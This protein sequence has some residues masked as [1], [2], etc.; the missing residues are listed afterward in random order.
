MAI[1]TLPTEV[2]RQ[3][4]KLSFVSRR[5]ARAGTGGEHVSRRPAPSTDFVDYRPYHP[6][7]D[8]RRVDWNIYGRLG[9]LQVKVTEGRERLSV[10]IVLDCSSSMDFGEP[11]KLTF[12]CQLV[13]ALAHIGVCRAD[14]VR[15]TCLG[16][17]HSGS[18]SPRR[19][20]TVSD[21][22]RQ[23]SGVAPVGLVDLNAGLATCVPAGAAAPSGS[24]AVI[25]SDLLTPE[26]VMLGLDALCAR[27]ADVALVHVVAPDELE[28]RLSGEVTLVDAESG[29][30]LELGVST[31]TLSAYRRR[32]EAWV[33]AREAD[34]RGRGLR[35]FRVQTDRPI[36]SVILS[37]LRQGGL[38]R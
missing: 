31:A 4:E 10:L 23:V 9:S 29:A 26:G 17:P 22:V 6:G 12:A 5:P 14:T 27:V 36:A 37:D 18:W 16:Q 25:V 15:V 32:F 33:N 30:G 13:T 38:L 8:F 21:V 1:A 11:N 20:P 28:P 34:C 35:Y 2:L 24:L 7:D 19:R 3:F